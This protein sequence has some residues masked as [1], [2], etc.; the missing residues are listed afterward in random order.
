MKELIIKTGERMLPE[1]IESGEEYLIY[2]RLL[3]GYEFAKKLLPKDGYILDIGCGQGYGANVLSQSVKKIVG[4]DVDKKTILD[5]LNKYETK[6]CSFQLYNGIKIPYE[7]NTFD[8]AVSFHV[9]EHIKDDINFIA[10]VFRV[11]KK[12]GT[13]ILATPNKI[14]R[15]KPNQKP[16]NRFHVREYYPSELEN[17]LKSKF[18]DVRILGLEGNEEINKIEFKRVKQNLRIVSFDP[19]NLR[20]LIPALAEASIIRFIRKAFKSKSKTKTDFA[21]KFN[22]NDFSLTDTGIAH[23]LDLLGISK[24]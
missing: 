24:K 5:I 9:I 21:R 18:S 19:L 22:V 13:F 11:L 20:R 2:L 16:W 12:R 6:N 1:K 7:D 14:Y 8:G 10:E 23:S 17:L 15:L 3:F 4:L